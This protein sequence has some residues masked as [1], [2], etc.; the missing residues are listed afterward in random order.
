MSLS[1]WQQIYFHVQCLWQKSICASCARVYRDSTQF[2]KTGNF[3]IWI[4][5]RWILA[6]DWWRTEPRQDQTNKITKLR[7]RTLFRPIPRLYA[8][9][10]QGPRPRKNPGLW[11]K[12]LL[13][14]SRIWGQY[15]QSL[16]SSRT[17]PKCCA[18]SARLWKG[19]TN[20]PDRKS[21]TDVLVLTEVYLNLDAN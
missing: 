3:L 15:R 2:V 13:I 16:G 1:R 20:F 4:H 14:K 12:K 19:W 10:W 8:T 7:P 18:A 11:R 6:C 17:R 21:L 5:V 9:Q